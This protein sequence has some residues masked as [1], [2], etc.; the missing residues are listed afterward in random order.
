MRVITVCEPMASAIDIGG[1]DV[2]NR[3]SRIPLYGPTIIHAGL[4]LS[5]FTQE[6]CDWL[7]ERWPQFPRNRC[8]AMDILNPRRGLALCVAYFGEPWEFG[9]PRPGPVS[10]WATGP[11]C[12]P[13]LGVVSIKNPFRVRGQQGVFT[14]PAASL[15]NEVIV[16]ADE[17]T[18]KF[19]RTA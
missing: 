5:W 15:P 18:E 10:R 9:S 19:G 12:F 6:N 4:G 17:L 14:V 8:R 3:R 2:E 16:A 13:V 11:W 1:K 7:H